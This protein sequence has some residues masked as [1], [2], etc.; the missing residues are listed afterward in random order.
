MCDKDKHIR[1]EWIQNMKVKFKLIIKNLQAM[2]YEKKIVEEMEKDL[3]K[4][5]NKEENVCTNQNFLG[6]KEVFRGDG[7]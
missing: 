4:Y 1:D 3:E 6:I 7:C 2:D 5:F